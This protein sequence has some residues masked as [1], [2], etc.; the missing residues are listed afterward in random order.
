MS[1]SRPSSLNLS[2]ADVQRD[3]EVEEVLAEIAKRSQK[4]VCLKQRV[5]ELEKEVERLSAREHRLSDT[6]DELYSKLEVKDSRIGQLETINASLMEKHEQLDQVQAAVQH[7]RDR[8][9]KA[10]DDNSQLSN[11][12]KSKNAQLEAFETQIV[13]GKSES[14]RKV[15]WH[16]Q[17]V[18]P[19]KEHKVVS[20]LSVHSSTGASS[21]AKPTLARGLPQVS[22]ALQAEEGRNPITP[23]E[24]AA[25]ELNLQR[26]KKMQIAK[27]QMQKM[28]RRWSN[29]Y[30]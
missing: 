25:L 6:N 18:I 20:W 2:H 14:A 12:L 24:E 17:D 13:K 15:H 11:L 28:V 5:S 27:A 19:L 4:S 8:L 9:T 29:T 7:T 10:L 21:A 1:D 16:D 23:E 3:K 22:V 26:K 30:L